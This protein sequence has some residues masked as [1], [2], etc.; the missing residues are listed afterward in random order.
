MPI[1]SAEEINELVYDAYGS[2]ARDCKAFFDRPGGQE[3]FPP[4][5]L[6]QL[7]NQGRAGV[8][9]ALKITE[10]T[11]HD[12]QGGSFDYQEAKFKYNM[13]ILRK[14][15]Q[16]MKARN[17][18]EHKQRYKDYYDQII[19][20]M[21]GKKK[22]TSM[23]QIRRQMAE[24]QSQDDLNEKIKAA[25]S[26]IGDHNDGAERKSKVANERKSDLAMSHQGSSARS[27]VHRNKQKHGSSVRS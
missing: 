15:V 27:P 13:Q 26:S 2:N 6:H 21:T 10:N 9:Q 16:F 17:N 20:E 22:Q 5:Y 18:K 1:L 19:S 12:S 3:D 25:K 4:C 24:T 8:P 11:P 7:D 23:Y 14:I